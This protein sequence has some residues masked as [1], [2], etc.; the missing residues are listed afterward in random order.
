VATPA[1]PPEQAQATQE[2]LAAL[3]LPLLRAAWP[4]FDP[5][6]LDQ[7]VPTF[8]EA[9]SAVVNRYGKASAAL[10]L[11][12]YRAVRL[13]AG[14][15]GRPSI[16]LV[17]DVPEGFIDEA[18]AESLSLAM[19][20]VDQQVAAAMAEAEKDMA[21][22]TSFLDSQAQ[23]LVLEQGRRQ[24]L[25]AVS[26]DREAKGWARITNV[27][28]CSFCLMLAL[29]AGAGYLYTSKRAASFK[30]HTKQPDGSGGDCRCVPEP[31][32]GHYEPPARVRDAQK[33]WE[34]STKGRSGHDAR[35][36]FRQ[37]IEGREV[38]GAPGKSG[39]R[40]TPSGRRSTY[41]APKGKTPETQRAQ[42]RVLEAMPPAK[43]PEAAEWRRNRIA[44]IHTYLGE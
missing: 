22:A 19:P 25:S 29:R 35:V 15:P 17:S 31:V 2:T 33:V 40:R 30:A 7:T 13:D 18:L 14:I 11:Q 10:S 24:M 38:T 4:L 12:H 34:S 26:L 6:R 20:S 8:R 43:S 28:A 16:P 41:A 27:G 9:V 23:H 32:F 21:R 3:V 37:A 36:A 44:E 5:N 42:L 39:S 1:A